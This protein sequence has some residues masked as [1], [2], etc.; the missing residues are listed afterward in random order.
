M[1]GSCPSK[2]AMLVAT[3]LCGSDV[4]CSTVHCKFSPPSTIKAGREIAML[5]RKW[6]GDER[7]DLAGTD[8]VRGGPVHMDGN[9]SLE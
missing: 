8:N 9:T 4:N 1:F 6:T 7:R 2:Y 5:D 3:I